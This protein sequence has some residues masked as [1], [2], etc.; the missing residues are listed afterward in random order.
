M[1]LVNDLISTAVNERESLRTLHGMV[2]GAMDDCP[3]NYGGFVVLAISAVLVTGVMVVGGREVLVM[4]KVVIGWAGY[5]V[6]RAGQAARWYGSSYSRRDW[7]PLTPDM[8]SELGQLPAAAAE[9]TVDDTLEVP[10]S[11]LDG[12]Q[13]DPDPGDAALISAFASLR[14]LPDISVFVSREY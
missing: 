3:V 5:C 6:R 14:L 2:Q 12:E 13:A 9:Q 4:L 11:G 1:M 8:M 7:V 10:D